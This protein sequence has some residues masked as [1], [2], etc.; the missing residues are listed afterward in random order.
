MPC[1]CFAVFP[2][3]N[4]KQ[5]LFPFSLTHSVFFCNQHES[6]LERAEST[7]FVSSGMYASVA[8]FMALV[9]AKG[10]IVTT[11]D[12]Y[13]KTRIFIEKELPKLGITVIYA[14]NYFV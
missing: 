9:P 7:L 13:R 5:L 3:R 8:L 14:L 6:A 11:T 2:L 4:L 12:C 1:S 10:H